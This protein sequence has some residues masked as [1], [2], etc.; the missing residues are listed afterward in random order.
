MQLVR[1]LDHG[2]TFVQNRAIVKVSI[3]MAN[4]REI[5][6]IAEG[7]E[8][9]SSLKGLYSKELRTHSCQTAHGELFSK[10][11]PD[12]A[13]ETLFATLKLHECFRP[14][15]ITYQSADRDYMHFW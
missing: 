13:F 8:R 10:R 15:C 11:L 7:V 14:M 4:A 1:K 2:N 5:E 6:V 9:V 3:A 12:Y